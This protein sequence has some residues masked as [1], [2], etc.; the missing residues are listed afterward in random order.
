MK[1]TNVVVPLQVMKFFGII[2]MLFCA[3][4]SHAQD[5]DFSGTDTDSILLTV[6]LKHQQDKNLDSIQS[7]SFKNRFYESFPPGEARVVSWNVAMGLGQIV[8]L[9]FPS[10]YLR[11]VN[12]AIEKGAWGAFDTEI[13]VTYDFFPVWPVLK[14]KETTIHS[15]QER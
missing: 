10:Q 15:K 13:Y 9:K 1:F 2:T 12:L 8:T 7:I 3:T 14:D 4:L 5:K 6:I 11:K